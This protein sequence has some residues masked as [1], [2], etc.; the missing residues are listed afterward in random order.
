[1]LDDVSAGS[2]RSGTTRRPS[3]VDQLTKA[4]VELAG[5]AGPLT[6]TRRGAPRPPAPWRCGRAAAGARRPPRRPA[7]AGRGREDLHE[8][9]GVRADLHELAAVRADLHELERAGRSA[10]ARGRGRAARR[11]GLRGQ[12]AVRA[13]V[14][15]R[16]AVGAVVGGGTAAPR[17]RRDDLAALA[18]AV[19][20]LDRLAE[21]PSGP[22][23]NSPAPGVTSPARRRRA[24]LRAGVG[25]GAPGDAHAPYRRC[26]TSPPPATSPGSPRR[27]APLQ[28]LALSGRTSPC[29]P[30][31]SSRCRSWPG[32]GGP[33]DARRRR[34]TVAG[35]RAA[36]A[37]LTVLAGAVEPL[38]ELARTR[39]DLARLSG[40]V[41]PLQQLGHVR[42]DLAALRRRDR[43]GRC[44]ASARDRRRH[45]ATDDD[46]ATPRLVALDTANLAR[47]PTGPPSHR[48]TSARIDALD[49]RSGARRHRPLQ[50]TTERISR[51]VDHRLRTGPGGW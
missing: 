19:A 11:P 21:E 46:S 16:T 36:Q 8:L 26:R 39:Q 4:V 42:A 43:R 48:W 31:R 13:R 24:A 6:E 18:G 7:R 14:G 2:S 47:P 22:C 37:D 20:A 5:A 28:E 1:M 45:P 34:R 33:H 40:A 30:V 3:P 50:G 29:S 9:A 15:R 49:G 41:E 27:S 25:P 10:R 35:A 12:A 51:I 44:G 38:R 32:P 23:R 17:R